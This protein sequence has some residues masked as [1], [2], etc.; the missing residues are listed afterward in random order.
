MS[1]KRRRGK[2]GIWWYYWSENG[3][4][5]AKSLHTVDEKDAEVLKGV[6]D[7]RR[8]Y[9][10]SGLP[11][12]DS[13]WD[14]FLPNY[15][16]HCKAN[17]GS[18]T[19]AREV[20]V[21]NTFTDSQ[22]PSLFKS[23]SQQVI[24]THLNK[25]ASA[26]SKAN[27]NVHYRHLKAIFN[28]AVEWGYIQKSPFAGIKQFRIDE[29]A[30]RFLSKEEISETIARA[31]KDSNPA[32][33]GLL[34]AFLWTGMRL[35]EVLGLRWEAIDFD[36]G[37]I[38]AFGKGRKERDI[39][40]HPK[41]EAYLRSRR[42][43]DGYVFGGEAPM[44]KETVQHIFRDRL[45]PKGASIHTLRHTFASHAVMRKMDLRTLQEIL[46]HTVIATT[47]IY[48]HLSKAHI[49]EGMEKVTY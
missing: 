32:S 36:R 20:R 42:A 44:S 30:P 33:Y 15:L 35:S 19:Y 10:E 31:K 34:M 11:S 1:F 3:R 37:W 24:E 14:Q 5:R 16:D 28:K 8:L 25:I 27:A 45:L 43:K 47:M 2:E 9:N 46:G 21:L 12:P 18:E 39:P 13:R 7:R 40:L 6:E 49:K 41:L 17:K 48:S 23:L 29:K 22:K 4:K 26:T 38:K